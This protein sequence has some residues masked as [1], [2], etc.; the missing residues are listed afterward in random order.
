MDT[1]IDSIAQ[2]K[3]LRTNVTAKESKSFEKGHASN[4]EKNKVCEE[5]VSDIQSLVHFL[6]HKMT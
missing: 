5:L 6:L 3:C 2:S 1:L 4:T